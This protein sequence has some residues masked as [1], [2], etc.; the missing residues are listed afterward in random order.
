MFIKKNPNVENFFINK[1]VICK[2]TLKA[3][4]IKAPINKENIFIWFAKD[5]V[6]DGKY[7]N[8]VCIGII[9][10]KLYELIFQNGITKEETIY[11]KV[12]GE[13]LLEMFKK[14]KLENKQK[15]Y[16]YFSQNSSMIEEL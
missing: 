9:K 10:N 14:Q 5:F 6:R 16:N 3:I 7:P 1:K 13:I 2:E 8:S 12:T 4:K 15:T 11:D